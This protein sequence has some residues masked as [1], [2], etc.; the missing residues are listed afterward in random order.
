MEGVKDG[1]I[2]QFVSQRGD[3]ISNQWSVIQWLVA[4]LTTKDGHFVSDAI[5]GISEFGGLPQCGPAEWHPQADQEAVR[6]WPLWPLILQDSG[7]FVFLLFVALPRT[8]WYPMERCLM[9]K[10]LTKLVGKVKT[11]LVSGQRTYR[12]Y[13]SSVTGLNKLDII[14]TADWPILT[15]PGL[16]HPAEDL[17]LA[18]RS[19]ELLVVSWRAGQSHFI[20]PLKLRWTNRIP[21]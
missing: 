7:Q 18:R 1:I 16:N 6:G 8:I 17:S 19:L 15:A 2:W 14:M 13:L 4:T 21:Q 10:V 20:A 12:D 3:Q 5:V 9:M 11:P